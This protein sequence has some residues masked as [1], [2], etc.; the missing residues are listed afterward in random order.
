MRLWTSDFGLWTITPSIVHTSPAALPHSATNPT[1]QTAESVRLP[2]RS[3]SAPADLYF[4]T[5]TRIAPRSFAADHRA[6]PLVR[7]PQCSPA[8]RS[9]RCRPLATALSPSL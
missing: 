3:S 8:A 9:R 6:A 4:E 1:A 2:A 5:D 7:F